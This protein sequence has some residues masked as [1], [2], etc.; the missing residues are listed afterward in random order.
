MFRWF[1]FFCFLLFD[2]MLVSH[3]WQGYLET[4]YGHLRRSCHGELNVH[5]PAFLFISCYFSCCFYNYLWLCS[6]ASS[7]QPTHFTFKSCTKMPYLG[8]SLQNIQL[9]NLIFPFAVR[10]NI[11]YTLVVQDSQVKIDKKNT[12]TINGS[13]R[14]NSTT[15]WTPINETK[16]S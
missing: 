8:N 11:P 10:G 15:K 6:F 12:T 5:N 2:D 4:P 16:S 13:G 9:L 14:S 1:D 3:C 7:K